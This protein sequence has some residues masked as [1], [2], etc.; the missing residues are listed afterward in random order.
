MK[1][2]FM[3]GLTLSVLGILAGCNSI[4]IVTPTPVQRVS[5]Q[6]QQ[7]L[8]QITNVRADLTNLTDKFYYQLNS[9]D[10][11]LYWKNNQVYYIRVNDSTQ[12]KEFFYKSG[13]LSTVRV[14]DELYLFDN[15]R[16]SE[17]IN[18]KGDVLTYSVADKAQKQ[19]QLLNDSTRLTKMLGRTAADK[20][21]SLVRT[22]NDAKLNY[23]CIA[24]LKQV[25]NTNR[26]FRSSANRA[27]NSQQLLADVRLRGNE[28][29]V[30]NCKLNNNSV[31]LLTLKRTR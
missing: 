9:N 1:K 17:V 4:N 7:Y 31:V 29:Y 12:E 2:L 26:V 5:E 14:N 19:E 15:N 20:N 27:N 8:T 23:L 6:H 28:F 10:Y 13:S 21:L 16:L 11:R 3:R 25:A 24:K 18:Q 22:G 30:M